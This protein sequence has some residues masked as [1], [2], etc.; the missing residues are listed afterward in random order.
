[1]A[2]TTTVRVRTDTRDRIKRLAREDRVSA[3]DL[4]ERLVDKEEQDR[5]LQA[6]NEDFERLRDDPGAWA[7]FQAETARW[8]TTSGDVGQPE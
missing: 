1:M 7:D 6:M 8:D 5:L 4:I 2:A 3:P